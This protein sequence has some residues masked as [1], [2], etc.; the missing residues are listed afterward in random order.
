[1]LELAGPP[2]K[3]AAL[4]GLAWVRGS[5]AGNGTGAGATRGA[6]IG[7]GD[8]RVPD[9]SA[10]PSEPDVRTECLLTE[11]VGGENV[12]DSEEDE[13]EWRVDG[14]DEAVCA[15]LTYSAPLSPDGAR[16]RVVVMGAP[17]S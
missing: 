5:G 13:P 11:N 8:P 16:G 6:G 7:S 2:G 1:V 4:P 3:R 17:S 15:G 9:V 10:L 12:E 14:D